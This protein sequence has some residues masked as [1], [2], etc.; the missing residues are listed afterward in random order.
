L[1][2]PDQLEQKLARQ[3]GALSAFKKSRAICDFI[4]L[5]CDFGFFYGWIL[6]WGWKEA[7]EELAGQE[8]QDLR[9]VAHRRTP[10]PAPPSPARWRWRSGAAPDRLVVSVDKSESCPSR[11][12]KC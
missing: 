11:L 4:S 2:L 5:T 8:E 9:P 7:F 12:H 1:F 3:T 6:R 10:S